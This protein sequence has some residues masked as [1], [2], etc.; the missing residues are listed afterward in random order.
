MSTKKTSVAKPA[1]EVTAYEQQQQSVEKMIMEAVKSNVSV[2]T[3]ERVLAMRKE[4]KAEYAKTQFDK[5]MANFQKECPVIK[6]NTPVYEKNQMNL[7]PNQRLV[8]YYYASL[9]SIVSQTK[10]VIA[11]N[12][13]S[14][15]WNTEIS[16]QG[17][18]VTCTVK[19]IEGHSE[20]SSFMVPVG[21]EQFMTEVQKYGARSTFAKRYAFCDAFGIM[22]GDED[23]DAQ[24]E[25]V[26]NP[27]V[28][29]ILEEIGQCTTDEQV[30]Q[31]WKQLTPQQKSNSQIVAK[32]KEMRRLIIE[33]RKNEAA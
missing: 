4:L 15:T 1:K 24:G 19:H 21:Q 32:V 28:D 6:K 20:S 27:Q 26:G 8:R 3:M 17:L 31:K 23:T 25:D 16:E 2:E 11:R 9:D 7:P 13:L 33:A 30:I 14:Y 12:N 29:K 18:K 10:D 5:A 22:T